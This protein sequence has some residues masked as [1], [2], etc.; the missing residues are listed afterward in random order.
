LA[1]QYA[2][3]ARTRKYAAITTISMKLRLLMA[4][5]PGLESGRPSLSGAPSVPNDETRRIWSFSPLSA[6]RM[7][8]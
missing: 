7:P 1:A 3:A 2:M 6:M 4:F 5:G 8:N